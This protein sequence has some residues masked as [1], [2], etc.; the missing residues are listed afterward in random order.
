MFGEFADYYVRNGKGR[1]I[2]KAEV[3]EILARADAA[4]LVLQ[5]TN[6]QRIGAICCCCSCCCGVLGGLKSQP[7]PAEAVVNAFIA[8]LEQDGCVACWTCLE[9]CQMDALSEAGDAVALDADR[10][11]GCGLCVSTC[12]SGA[13]T[14][15]R[16]PESERTRVPPTLDDTWH[17]IV[18]A[19]DAVRG[20]SG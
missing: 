14:L 9:R 4:N 17:T 2:D 12:P 18:A 11:I 20:T 19:Q 1:A 6:S 3:Y 8:H 7:K 13:L 16:K 5:P 10:C 15:V